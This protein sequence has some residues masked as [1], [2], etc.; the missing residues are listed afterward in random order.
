M[1]MAVLAVIFTERYIREVYSVR[2]KIPLNITLNRIELSVFIVYTLYSFFTA[3]LHI[4]SIREE[5]NHK[6]AEDP[7]LELTKPKGFT[8][9]YEVLEVLIHLYIIV[10]KLT[11]F[12]HANHSVSLYLESPKPVPNLKSKGFRIIE[13][14][15]DDDAGMQT[16]DRDSTHEQDSKEYQ[17]ME[18]STM[19]SSASHRASRRLSSTQELQSAESAKRSTRTD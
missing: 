5:L 15:G 12:M 17:L 4:I 18:A 3:I 1:W 13:S 10:E 11:H 16:D 6:Y 9:F 14:D 19:S 7:K 2:K 8:L